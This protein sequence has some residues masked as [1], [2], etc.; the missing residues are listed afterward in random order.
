M[1]HLSTCGACSGCARA[2]PHPRL[3]PSEPTTLDRS[4]PRVI[5][6]TTQSLALTHL[7]R[8]QAHGGVQ[9]R[10]RLRAAARPHFLLIVHLP[11]RVETWLAVSGA[12]LWQLVAPGRRGP[13][14]HARQL[15]TTYLPSRRK[16]CV[17]PPAQRR[18]SC[19]SDC[20]GFRVGDE[21]TRP[22]I[23]LSTI[24]ARAEGHT[25]DAEVWALRLFQGP[26][27][28]APCQPTRSAR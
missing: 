20:E 1:G 6:S 28:V 10:L 24:V 25:Y 11:R 4:R 17:R 7:W 13:P 8:Q 9:F 18:E 23:S 16:V 12:A 19:E 22:P 21:L 27:S 15:K 14:G 26:F 2:A 3:L 5:A